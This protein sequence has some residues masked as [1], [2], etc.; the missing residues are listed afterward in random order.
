MVDFYVDFA[1]DSDELFSVVQK[2]IRLWRIVCATGWYSSEWTFE[3]YTYISIEKRNI[4]REK[5]HT[6]NNTV[7]VARG[8]WVNRVNR[9]RH[10]KKREHESN[11][12]NMKSTS[13]YFYT[14]IDSSHLFPM[15]ELSG[16]PGV[17]AHMCMYALLS[18]Y[19]NILD[20]PVYISS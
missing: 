3:N 16:G 1:L 17:C 9:V 6:K 2:K 19:R 8:K 20:Y 11:I 12:V 14:R 4:A 13:L 7:F 5:Y 15:H 10:E 18:L